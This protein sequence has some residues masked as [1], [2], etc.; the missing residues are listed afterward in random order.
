MNNKGLNNNRNTQGTKGKTHAQ[1]NTLWGH[2]DNMRQII[3]Q[4]YLGG[5]HSQGRA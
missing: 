2:D 4:T 1:T 3:K 5:E